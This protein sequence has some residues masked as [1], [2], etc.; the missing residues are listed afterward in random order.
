MMINGGAAEMKNPLAV[1]ARSGRLSPASDSCAI[2]PGRPLES[3]GD[4]GE[5]ADVINLH[6]LSSG[7]NCCCAPELA[8]KTL[9]PGRRVSECGPSEGGVLFKICSPP[10]PFG[11]VGI[12]GRG[13]A[14][15]AS[16]RRP[17]GQLAAPPDNPI[18]ARS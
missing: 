11:A 8:A 16:C 9:R 1:A 3:A 15:F 13:R 5:R 7:R 14:G 12:V 4:D 10:F 2:R 6:S 18:G 17:G